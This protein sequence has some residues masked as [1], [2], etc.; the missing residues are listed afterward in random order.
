MPA[1][2]GDYEIRLLAAESPY[3]TL[4]KL[5]LK[6]NAITATLD[7]PAQVPAG[8]NIQ[9]QWTG[10]NN[11][12]DYIGLGTSRQ[13]YLVYAYTRQGNPAALRAPD[14]SGEYELRYFLGTAD[15]AVATRKITIGAVSASV[16]GPAEAVAGTTV[17][18]QL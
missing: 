9:I 18:V 8:S 7:A 5:P 14:E 6:A 3:A 10:P 2:P 15:K 12:G 11:E 16:Q 4:A 1:T 17:T 13:P